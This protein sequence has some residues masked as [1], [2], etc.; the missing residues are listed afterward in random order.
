MMNQAFLKKDIKK[1][2]KL[3]EFARDMWHESRH[4]HSRI[5]KRKETDVI[6]E[7]Q[8]EYLEITFEIL[9]LIREIQRQR[10]NKLDV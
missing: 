5:Y 2:E 3:N 8:E 1:L 7:E 6:K 10:T 9:D 4:A